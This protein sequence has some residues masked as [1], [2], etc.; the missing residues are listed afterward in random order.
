MMKKFNRIF[1]LRL[2]VLCLGGFLYLPTTASVRQAPSLNVTVEVEHF[3]PVAG[4]SANQAGTVG[5]F[6]TFH[7]VGEK[8]ANQAGTVES[9]SVA[10]SVLFSSMNGIILTLSAS[11]VSESAALGQTVG[12]LGTLNLTNPSFVLVDGAGGKF[13]LAGNQLKVA[14]KLDFETSPTHTVRI[15]AVGT[16][17]QVERDF[18]LSVLD[19]IDDDDD[20]DGLTQAREKELGTNVA[21]AD[22][23]GDG[24][25]DGAEVQAGS[26]PLDPQ[27]FPAWSAQ[28]LTLR[29]DGVGENLPAGTLAG[30]FLYSGAPLAKG[31]ELSVQKGK[32]DVWFE[33]G[34]DAALQTKKV[35]D[36]ES[37]ESHEVT[38]LSKHPSG[39]RFEKNFT[40]P[41]LDSFLPVVETGEFTLSGSSSATLRGE[42]VDEGDPGGVAEHG[43]VLSLRPK[44]VIGRTGVRKL[45]SGSGM[46]AVLVTVD[47][48]ERGKKY[49]YRAYARNAE[50]IAYGSESSFRT[51][52][53]AKAPAW[54]DARKSSSP[55]WWNSR[56]L[57]PIYR[58]GQSAWVM[59]PD[60][61][62]L[63][64]ME[65][66]VQGVWLW[67]SRMGWLWTDAQYYPFL[68]QNNSGGWL[69][70]YGTRR[71]QSLFY[72]YRDSRWLAEGKGTQ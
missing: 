34:K 52:A 2:S 62:W 24:F 57:G 20:G 47:G 4:S 15:R 35:L 68:Y 39:V 29:T 22:T 49:F 69:Y 8:S 45:S 55:G 18:L 14:G 31:I 3:Y 72:R 43:M 27:S 6:G 23:D 54:A 42:V 7:W 10:P 28:F 50:G 32:G 19:V 40:V 13:A 59:H 71:D 9:T 56:W 30:E 36:F 33:I 1:L 11:S 44:P 21:L 38:V 5:N 37:M 60:L 26:N 48:L 53:E 16:E 51:S 63:F 46:G 64:P 25:S 12:S 17:G 67:R 61:G 41:V 66:P 70:Y 58:S 65:S